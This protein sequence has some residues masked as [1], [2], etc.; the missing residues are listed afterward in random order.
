MSDPIRPGVEGWRKPVPGWKAGTK[1][2]RA[3]EGRCTGRLVLR[4]QMSGAQG[5]D[6]AIRKIIPVQLNYLAF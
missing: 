6:G 4:N 5:K 3:L 2:K 1:R